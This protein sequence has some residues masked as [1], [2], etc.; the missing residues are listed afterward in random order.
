[1][2]NKSEDHVPLEQKK[3]RLTRTEQIEQLRS[4]AERLENLEKEQSRKR[5]AR[6]KIVIGGAVIAEAREDEAFRKQLIQILKKH[7]TRTPDAE[8]IAIWLS[9]M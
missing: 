9:S 3:R 6:Q 7:V 1:M 8:V 5:D 4:R 2:A